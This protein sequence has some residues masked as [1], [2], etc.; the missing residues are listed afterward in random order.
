MIKQFLGQ[1]FSAKLSRSVAWRVFACFVAIEIV[2]LLPS[3]FR[4]EEQLAQ[5]YETQARTT[6][7][8]W[9][10]LTQ[11]D[12]SANLRRKIIDRAIADT[13][14]LGLSIY[15]LNGAK[16]LGTGAQPRINL[17]QWQQK[18]RNYEYDSAQR[19]IEIYIESSQINADYVVLARFDATSLNQELF[20]Y[21]MRILG[22]ILL[23]GA[24]VTLGTV[25]TLHPK[26][27]KPIY[28]L[29][30]DLLLVGD[31]IAHDSAQPEM[32]SE[33]I[34]KDELGDVIQV[35]HGFVGEIYT[36]ISARK[37]V[38]VELTTLNST[39]QDEIQHRQVIEENLQKLNEQLQALAN[40][41]GLTQVPNRRS[42]D[43]YLDRE[44]RRMAREKL[45]ISLIIFD[46]DCFKQFNDHYG[47]QAGDHCLIQIAK[48][49]QSAI[50]RP[51][52]FLARYGGEEF[53]AVLPNTQLEGAKVVAENLRN[54]ILSLK[55]PHEFSAASSS[56]TVSL[57]IATE[58]PMPNTHHSELIQ[59]ADDAL[60][61]AKN[62]GR[63]RFYCAQEAQRPG[64][65]KAEIG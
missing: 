13:D 33:L 62:N 9:I 44:W 19:V 32:Q 61:L 47:H 27:M 1:S 36:A 26:V 38:E 37:E 55:I 35:F 30:K 2:V 42:F 4:R 54:A 49:S 29:R 31:A 12:L 60:Y 43:E 45:P 52:D 58:I 11:T 65:I 51:A 24:I 57:G 6:L 56:V 46:V 18:S 20:G 28:Q 41:D 48:A 17:R 10:G 22:L 63:D 7:A 59:K 50:Q 23:I 16:R 3:Y 53:V 34:Q 15:D 8:P 64:E 14:L 21:V 39:L 25:L 40:S 5:T